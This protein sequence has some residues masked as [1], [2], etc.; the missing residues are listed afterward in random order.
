MPLSQAQAKHH[1]RRVGFGGK[2]TEVNLFGQ[3][4]RTEAV[5]YC[6]DA[7]PD[8]PPRPPGIDDT[9]WWEVLTQTQDWWLQRMAD[10]RWHNRD[11]ATPSPL[12]EKM[13]LF[14]H[15]HFAT[16]ISKIEDMRSMWDQHQILRNR[17]M[18]NLHTLLEQVCTNGAILS[19][20]DNDQN[21]KWDPQENFARELMEL[22]TIGPDAFV[23]AD[24]IEMTRAWTG[25]GI[26]GWVGYHDASYEYHGSAHDGS[27]KILFDL[28][29][30]RW[31]GP[32]TLEIFTSGVRRDATARFIANKLWH[33]FV[34][35]HPTEGQLQ[36]VVD[37]FLPNLI[38]RD[39]L[40]EILNHGAF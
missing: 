10:A 5:D 36:D 2:S 13:A 31:N 38:I 33:F 30:Q 16:G 8:P 26:V 34:N 29:P 21:T 4:E 39:A 24:V 23:E 7:L 3:M 11:S 14:W 35:D 32:D 25:H 15:S 18:G 20:L 12:E 22:Y 9:N 17:G 37:A 6:L 1:C 27:N 19:Y 28:P 40:R